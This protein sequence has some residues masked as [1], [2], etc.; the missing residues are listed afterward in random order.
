MELRGS[1]EHAYLI[2]LVEVDR[3][4][5]KELIRVSRLRGDGSEH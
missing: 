1:W 5:P 4:G 2:A 3:S